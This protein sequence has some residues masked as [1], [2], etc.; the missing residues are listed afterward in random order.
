MG[1]L[2]FRI[3]QQ[4]PGYERK[5]VLYNVQ[6]QVVPEKDPN[7]RQRRT[8]YRISEQSRERSTASVSSSGSVC[9]GASLVCWTQNHFG[10][11]YA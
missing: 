10:H 8:R 11:A 7:H 1:M 5:Y 3:L 9:V 4:E 2:P 6:P